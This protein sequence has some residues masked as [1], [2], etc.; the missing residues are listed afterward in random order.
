MPFLIRQF[1]FLLTFLFE[2]SDISI[3][4]ASI[5]EVKEETGLDFNPKKL[6]GIFELEIDTV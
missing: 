6:W 5:R 4:E 2:H 3:E 1:V